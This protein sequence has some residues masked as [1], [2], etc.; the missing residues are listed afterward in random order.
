M[1]FEKLKRLERECVEY[2][3]KAAERKI[4]SDRLKLERKIEAA[5]QLLENEAQV[6]AQAEERYNKIKEG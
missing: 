4:N 3:A 1:Q 6:R 5:R 2:S